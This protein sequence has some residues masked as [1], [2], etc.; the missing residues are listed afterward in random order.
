[1]GITPWTMT[2]EK[3][4]DVRDWMII[5][6]ACLSLAISGVLI[7]WVLQLQHDTHRITQNAR[8]SRCWAGVL[9][10]ALHIPHPT[11]AEHVKLVFDANL[12]TRYLP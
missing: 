7:Y 1:M 11:A 4:D 10:E 5:G 6:L 3:L 8:A 2:P 9:D 12:C